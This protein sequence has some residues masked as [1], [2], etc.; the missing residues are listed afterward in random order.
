MG[1]LMEVVVPASPHCGISRRG[2]L[3]CFSL[4]PHDRR[5][6]LSR[7]LLHTRSPLSSPQRLASRGERRPASLCSSQ[8]KEEGPRTPFYWCLRERGVQSHKFSRGRTGGLHHETRTCVNL[9]AV[10]HRS[11]LGLK[12]VC[13]GESPAPLALTTPLSPLPSRPHAGTSRHWW[14]YDR[15]QRYISSSLG[16]EC[17]MSK[18]LPADVKR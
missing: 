18:E 4:P 8:R 5:L 13:C 1:K 16:Y 9:Q 6:P 10:L 14:N 7:S 2:G 12:S 3:T 11:L 17:L 15:N